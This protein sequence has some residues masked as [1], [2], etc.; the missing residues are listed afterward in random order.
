M[1][2][3]AYSEGGGGKWAL[4]PP[5]SSNLKNIS[6]ERRKMGKIVGYWQECG[7]GGSERVKT[8]HT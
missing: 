8:L 3:G 7:E 6:I 5:P 2:L 4:L 1:C